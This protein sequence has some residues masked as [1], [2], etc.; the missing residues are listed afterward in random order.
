MENNNQKTID[1]LNELVEINND[2]VA[3]YEN[4]AKETEQE[5]LKTIFNKLADDSRQCQNELTSQVTKLGGTP[6]KGTSTSGKVYRVWMDVRSAL[7]N[8]DRHA[9][10]SS[11]ETGEDVAVKAYE[12]ALDKKS[13]IDTEGAQIIQKQATIIRSGHDKVKAL[14]DSAK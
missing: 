11:C 8:K 1:V 10:L 5:D 13:E 6:K 7:T 2:R 12:S 9:I 3:G 14:R 4:A